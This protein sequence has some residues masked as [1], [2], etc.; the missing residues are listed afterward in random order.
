MA[1]MIKHLTTRYAHRVHI[2][3]GCIPY[4]RFRCEFD[5]RNNVHD[6]LERPWPWPWEHLQSQHMW[7]PQETTNVITTRIV[8]CDYIENRRTRSPQDT[9]YMST[10]RMSSSASRCWDGKW[11]IIN[12]KSVRK[13][14]YSNCTLVKFWEKCCV[15][16]IV[17]CLS[18]LQSNNLIMW[19][20][21]KVYWL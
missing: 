11:I 7:S 21:S 19:R 10:P 20:S 1:A 16:V 17:V 5:T 3:P 4:Q 2:Y 13:T 9:M 15:I 6:L 18:M 14:S 12:L 8:V